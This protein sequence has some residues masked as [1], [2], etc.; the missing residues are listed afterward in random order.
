MS[1]SPTSQNLR[2][3]G[4]DG[5]LEKAPEGMVVALCERCVSLP[6]RHF[7]WEMRCTAC[8]LDLNGYLHSTTQLTHRVTCPDCVWMLLQELGGTP[9]VDWR[10][11]Q[12]LAEDLYAA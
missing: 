8:A 10:P 2:C 12:A 4:C 7:I 9:K 11:E 5:A 3:A 6:P 1:T